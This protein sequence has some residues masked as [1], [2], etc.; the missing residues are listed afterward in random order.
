MEN[1][2]SLLKLSEYVKYSEFIRPVCLPDQSSSLSPGTTCTIT[3]WG[4]T[5]EGIYKHISQLVLPIRN[6]VQPQL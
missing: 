6:W 4:Y 2:I 5:I 1:D 3:G